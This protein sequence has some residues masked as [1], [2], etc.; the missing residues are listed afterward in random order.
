M[1]AI[2]PTLVN[3]KYMLFLCVYECAKLCNVEEYRFVKDF[4]RKMNTEEFGK[5]VNMNVEIFDKYC[6]MSR[7]LQKKLDLPEKKNYIPT[8]IGT[9]IHSYG[10]RGLTDKILN[11][12]QG[13]FREVGDKEGV[14]VACMQGNMRA[15]FSSWDRVFA[16]TM[17]ELKERPIEYKIG[18]QEIVNEYERVRKELLAKQMYSVNLNAE[19]EQ[20]EKRLMI[21]ESYIEL[22]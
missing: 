16:E 17:N 2:M 9:L 19:I 10:T 8:S 22:L 4:V 18:R 7:L 15:M 3:K 12:I 14:F 5:F 20:L 21:L 6:E 11:N 13:V 1:K